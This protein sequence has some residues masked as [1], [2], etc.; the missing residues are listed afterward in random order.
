MCP[1]ANVVSNSAY[2][3]DCTLQ[4]IQL[5]QLREPVLA[6]AIMRT[7]YAMLQASA[8]GAAAVINNSAAVE[9]ADIDWEV[10]NFML[11]LDVLSQLDWYQ[12]SSQRMEMNTFLPSIH[13]IML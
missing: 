7:L 9:P 2:A 1:L 10:F 11:G 8:V 5:L 6:L 4:L 12:V 3:Y 13:R